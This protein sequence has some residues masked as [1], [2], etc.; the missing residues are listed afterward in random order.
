MSSE[1]SRSRLRRLFCALAGGVG[2][3]I[4]AGAATL[5]A[6]AAGQ[7][8]DYQPTDNA[9]AAWR[10]FAE[11]TQLRIRERLATDD[12]SVRQLNRLLDER[13]A[14]DGNP[15]NVVVKIWVSPVG[16][17]ERLEFD[18]L[19][20]EVASNLRAVL[21]GSSLHASPPQ[22]MLQPMHLML[23]LGQAN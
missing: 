13:R 21:I 1:S 22:N 15:L 8:N 23:S 17:V 12:G 16:A 3:T 2:I 10:Q 14:I 19:D 9:P 18:T 5:P 11:Q 6:A 7:A 4:G 20:M